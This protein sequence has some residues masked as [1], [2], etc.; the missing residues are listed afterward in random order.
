M[1]Y[2]KYCSL[3]KEQRADAVWK[4]LFVENTPI[5]EATRGVIFVLK[6]FNLPTGSAD[7]TVARKFF[8]E[9]KLDR[10]IEEVLRTSGV[11]TVIMTNDPLDPEEAP[12]WL[13]A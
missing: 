2:D 11:S 5:S 13:N 10:H 6:R 7:L 9:Q 8:R 12:M 4:T 1:S 3:T